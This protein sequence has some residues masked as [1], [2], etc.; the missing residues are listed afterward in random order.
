MGTAAVQLSLL[1]GAKP[2]VTAG[3]QAK[4]EMAKSLGALAGFNYKE[5]DFS[6]KVM[7]ATGGEFFFF[8]FFLLCMFISVC[9]CYLLGFGGENISARFLQKWG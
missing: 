1:A 3:S 4:I 8:C 2:I 6:E 7:Q 5:G 9:I